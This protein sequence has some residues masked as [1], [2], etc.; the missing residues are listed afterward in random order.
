MGYGSSSAEVRVT[1][2]GRP[3][4][5]EGLLSLVLGLVPLA[6]V[7]GVAGYSEVMRGA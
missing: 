3:L 2:E 6:F 1:A 4:I 7:G 5:P